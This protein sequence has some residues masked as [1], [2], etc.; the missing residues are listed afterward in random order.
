MR[1]ILNLT[2]LLSMSL[3]LLIGCSEEET[4]SK[5]LEQIYKEEGVPVKT[6]IVQPGSFS[7]SLDYNAKLTGIKE[8]SAYATFGDKVDKIYFNVGDKVN[9]DDV[10]LSFPTDNPTANY[11]QAKITY[12]NARSTYDRMKSYFESGGLSRQE[13]DN[14]EASYKVAQAN[15]DAV[16]QSVE[17]RAPISGVLTRINVQETENAEKEQE[18]FSIAQV[19]QLKSRIMVSDND[20]LKFSVGQSAKAVWNGIT[21][22]G[23]VTQVDQSMNKELNAFGVNLVFDNSGQK[24]PAGVTA[25]ILVDTYKQENSII[26]ARKN[27][28]TE[29]DQKFVYVNADGKAIKKEVMLGKTS[30]LDV[31]ISSGLNSGDE[32][33]TEGQ[34][35]LNDG[36]KIRVVN[37]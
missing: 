10:V 12:E 2:L 33:I 7:I 25:N 27:I 35:L 24:V 1:H 14:A 29:G 15:W 11:Y 34:M 23:K 13:F 4:E 31:E 21:L 17:V 18:L 8:S 20:I 28:V 36:T 37:Q 9:K 3:L 26:T 32:I 22:E 19:D 5:N 6:E 16:Q 30:G